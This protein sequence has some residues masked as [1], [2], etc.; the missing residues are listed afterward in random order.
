MIDRVVSLADNQA[1]K[2]YFNLNRN[3]IFPILIMM[4]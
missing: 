4:Q 2:N 3:Y 1:F